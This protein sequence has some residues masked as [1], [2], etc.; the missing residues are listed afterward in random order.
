MKNEDYLPERSED[1]QDLIIK[2]FY[3]LN[4]LFFNEEVDDDSIERLIHQILH[5]A[6]NSDE[7]IVIYVNTEGGDLYS[8]L[9]LYDAI[10]SIKN[11]VTVIAQGKA[12]SAGAFMIACLGTKE[13]VATKHTTFMIHEV[14][15]WAGG[16]FTEAKSDFKEHER[17]QKLWEKLLLKHTK[18]NKGQIQELFVSDYYFDSKKALELGFIDRVI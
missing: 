2:E 3:E 9:M 14:S 13:R 10:N 17:L 8:V 6:V 12:M 5:I 16:K 7:D 4:T 11:K 15:A 1:L 18:L